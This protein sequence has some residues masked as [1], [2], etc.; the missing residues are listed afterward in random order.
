MSLAFV[1]PQ[2]FARQEVL[3]YRVKNDAAYGHVSHI[4]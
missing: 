3:H 4:F 1:L 2:R